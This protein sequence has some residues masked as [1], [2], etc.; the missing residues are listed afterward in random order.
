VI[1]LGG[2]PASRS[3]KKKLRGRFF[4]LSHEEDDAWNRRPGHTGFSG[5]N[6]HMEVIEQHG[7]QREKF[8]VYIAMAGESQQGGPGCAYVDD[9]TGRAHYVRCEDLLPATFRANFTEFVQKDEIAHYFVVY[10]A[11]NALHVTSF[12]R[13]EAA[14]IDWSPYVECVRVMSTL[15]P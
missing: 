2:V 3:V 1:T 15:T 8:F 10:R 4:L 11:N 5:Q 7:L 13:L 12:S 6:T 9:D 14:K